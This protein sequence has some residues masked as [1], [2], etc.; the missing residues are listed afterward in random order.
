MRT[1][2]VVLVVLVSILPSCANP[3]RCAPGCES[4]LWP[5][6]IV[7]ILPPTGGSSDGAKLVALRVRDTTGH[8]FDGIP[9]GCP[10]IAGV[11]CTYSF[12][13]TPADRSVTVLVDPRDRRIPATKIELPLGPWN[14]C[15]RDITYARFTRSAKSGWELLDQRLLSP[16]A[17][18]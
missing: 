6:L 15:G 17:P 2:A 7:G 16:C 8:V 3:P 5:R 12:F 14:A 9:H 18:P 11:V 10:N 4:N 13:S 1:T